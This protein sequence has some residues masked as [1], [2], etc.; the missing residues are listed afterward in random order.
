MPRKSKNYEEI[1]EEFVNKVTQIF[2]DTDVLDDVSTL[3][4]FSIKDLE[5]ILRLLEDVKSNL[6]TF[7]RLIMGQMR[8]KINSMDLEQNNKKIKINRGVIK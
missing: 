2:E 3:D 8:N 6:N 1:R 7:S 5:H 4:N